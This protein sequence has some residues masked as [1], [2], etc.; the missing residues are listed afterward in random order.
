[1]IFHADRRRPH[2]ASVGISLSGSFFRVSA[3]DESRQISPG[4]RS[5]HCALQH[6]LLYRPFFHGAI[7]RHLCELAVSDENI[8]DNHA[9]HRI[10][11]NFRRLKIA[12]IT[13]HVFLRL[14]KIVNI[15]VT[16]F[17]L[18]SSEK[19]RGHA[20][21]IADRAAHES[22][23]RSVQHLFNPP[24]SRIRGVPES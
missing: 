19:R 14:E 17:D 5:D 7:E 15:A 10:V 20:H 23:V 1:M 11:S 16:F 18:R 12:V 9:F 21:S 13:L 8:A 6:F 3:F 2:S 4:G 22:A 24:I